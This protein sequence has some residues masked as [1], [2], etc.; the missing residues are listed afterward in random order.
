[1]HRQ[2]VTCTAAPAGPAVLLLLPAFLFVVAE[3]PVAG[4]GRPLCLRLDILVQL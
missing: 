2:G 3:N 1:M 4:G